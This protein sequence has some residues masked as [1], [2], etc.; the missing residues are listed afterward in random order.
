MSTPN[1]QTPALRK[2]AKNQQ[3]RPR[4]RQPRP[5][6]SMD[7]VRQPRAPVALGTATVVRNPRI[8]HAKNGSVS[9]SH[10][11]LIGDVN[12]SVG[13]SVSKYDINAGLLAMFPWLSNMASNYESYR[14]KRLRFRYSP[15]CSTAQKGY[16]Y[17]TTE[18]DPSDPVPDDEKQLA[19]FQGCVYG[20][21]WTPHMYNCTPK[22][23]HKRSSYYVRIG[24]LSAG[25]DLGLYDTGYLVVATTGNADNSLIGKLWV[26]YDVELSTPQLNSPAVGRALS[27]LFSGADDFATVPV[28]T[29]NA[30]LTASVAANA[31]TLTASQPY[32]GLLTFSIAGNGITAISTAGSTAA[33]SQFS[34]IVNAGGTSAIYSANVSFLTGST[35]VLD[36]NATT[37]GANR[38]RI[39]QYNVNNG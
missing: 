7:R 15:A 3:P 30:P 21:V 1:S 27:A 32:Q 14:F 20:S 34:T 28:K 2:K 8:V 29:G 17:L 33:L 25:A 18:F 24:S 16:V 37:I 6:Q 10:C 5:N 36:P 13:L 12:G 39:G 22:N 38:T 9:V 31:L 19:A 35:L 11:E 23:L 4:K 26:E